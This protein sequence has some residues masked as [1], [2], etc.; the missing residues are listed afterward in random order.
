MGKIYCPSCKA[1]TSTR[2]WDFMPWLGR[3]RLHFWCRKCHRWF[4]FCDRSRKLAWW[5]SIAALLLP[6]LGIRIY[7]EVSG[8]SSLDGPPAHFLLGLALVGYNTAAIGVLRSKAR[9]VGPVDA[10]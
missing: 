1:K 6:I 9:L 4:Q 10:P 2:F 7:F 8:A 5:A 3:G